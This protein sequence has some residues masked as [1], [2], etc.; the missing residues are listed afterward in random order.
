M[1]KSSR[2]SPY[3]QVQRGLSVFTPNNWSTNE[4]IERPVKMQLDSCPLTPESEHSAFSELQVTSIVKLAESILALHP[5]ILEVYIIE[6]RD[7]QNVVTDEASKSGASLLAEGMNQMGTNAPLSPSI[8]LGA[9]GQI[10]QGSKPTKL[11]G[12]LYAGGGVIMSPID[13]VTL[14]V[15]STT[16]SSL[17]DV[18]RSLADSLTRI[19][20][21]RGSVNAVNSASEAEDRAIAFLAK[22][23]Q[24]SYSSV[25]IDEVAYQNIEQVWSIHGWLQTRI[26]RRRFQ[27]N[28]A[29][30][31]GAILKFSST[32]SIS[33]DYL[34][35]LETACIAAAAALVAWLLY[36]KL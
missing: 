21:G 25:H 22:P 3:T 26:R 30:R 31:D 2:T 16:P 19:T 35:F 23:P 36:A 10:L 18:M 11:V 20:Q 28:V 1:D 9:A 33:L 34:L 6:E 15:A 4:S 14:F 24:Q 8:I 27:M 7:G 5:D 13:E 17:F 12:I 29:A 32:S